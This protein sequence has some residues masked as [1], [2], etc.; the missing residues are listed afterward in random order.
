L[1]IG[2]SG[3]ITFTVA[4][5]S[6]LDTATGSFEYL[7]YSSTTLNVYQTSPDPFANGQSINSFE[8]TGAIYFLNLQVPVT[9]NHAIIVDCE[10]GANIFRN[11]QIAANPYPV[12]IPNTFVI[13]G[14]SAL[15]TTTPNLYQQYYYFFYNMN[16]QLNN[17]PGTRTQVVAGTSIAP[18]ISIN[19]NLLTSTPAVSYQWY[20]NGSPLACE[21]RKTDTAILS[22]N[23]TV[24][25]TDSFGCTQTSN[26]I[27]FGGSIGVGGI[28]L[29][30]TPNPNNG[31]FQLQF[32]TAAASN[33]YVTL[34]N[35][36]GQQVYQ[37]SYP[38][39][40][41]VFSQ[42]INVG[43]L[44]GDVY[45]LKVFVGSNSYLQKI[46]IR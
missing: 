5:I 43:Y 30:V 40:A 32:E 2:H 21:T 41:G 26:Q 42:Q 16:L 14:N 24:A 46:V 28:Q 27:A 18:V 31:Q 20:L 11:N 38:N 3:T 35:T 44:S 36:I 23:Y 8:D 13:T 34:T 33:V 10:N 19:S 45:Y 22:G 7:P 29:K 25:A 4:D 37:A 12:G 17:C 9:G 6:N 39:F 15:S 1:Y